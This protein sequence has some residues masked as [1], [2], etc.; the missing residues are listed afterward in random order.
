M[1]TGQAASGHGHGGAEDHAPGAYASSFLT[2]QTLSRKLQ[3]RQ[4][5]VTPHS[6]LQE[7]LK[8]LTAKMGEEQEVTVELLNSLSTKSPLQ[9][10][11]SVKVDKN[12]LRQLK[13]QLEQDGRVREVAR[14]ASLGLPHAGSWLLATPIPTLGLHLKPSEFTMTG[15]Y[16]LGCQVYEEEGPC[17]ACLQVSDVFGDHALCCG[18][19]GERI[20]RHNQLRDHLHQLAASAALGPSK[21]SRFLLPGQDRRPADVFIPNWA[22]GLDAALDITV[23]NPLQSFTVAEASATPGHALEWRY[24]TKM[25][26]AAEEGGDLVS[27]SGC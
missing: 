20:T 16:R 27:P 12:N 5:E 17:P 11:I 15:R 13:E 6:L 22:A 9:K 3:G 1:G 2:S 4:E 26:G 21:E 7:L 23:V 14:L 19:G 25:D 10:A 24:G 8:V 18:H